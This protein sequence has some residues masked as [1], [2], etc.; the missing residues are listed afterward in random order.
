MP[1]LLCDKVVKSY[2]KVHNGGKPFILNVEHLELE[3]PGIYLLLGRNGAGKTTFIKSILHLLIPDAGRIELFGMSFK[4]PES[5]RMIGYVPEECSFPQDLVF[6][7]A[8]RLFNGL[9]GRRPESE[10]LANELIAKLYLNSL[11]NKKVSHLSRGEYQLLAIANAFWG[12]SRFLVCDEPLNGLDPIQKER[13]LQYIH[14]LYQRMDLTVLFSTHVLS[15]AEQV[16]TSVLLVKEGSVGQPL[17]R[18]KIEE[19]FGS[20]Y[21]FF[22]RATVGGEDDVV[23]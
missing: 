16:Y 12:V 14:Q 18:H 21:E 17:T 22:R 1:I 10:A 7:E 6:K 15:E 13:V 8:I 11:L 23:E 2:P 3:A 19:E 20:L 9:A 4:N 5:R